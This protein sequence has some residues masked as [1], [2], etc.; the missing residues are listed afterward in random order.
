MALQKSLGTE[1]VGSGSGGEDCPIFCL[2]VT[3]EA[4]LMGKPDVEETQVQSTFRSR[5][6]SL[7][8]AR[9]S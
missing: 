5:A 1:R 2:E 8:S 9:S 7:Q 6:P 3:G 4:D